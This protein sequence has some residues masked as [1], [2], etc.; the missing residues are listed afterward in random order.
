MSAMPL[1]FDSSTS[2]VGPV[3]INSATRSCEMS[4]VAAVTPMPLPTVFRKSRRDFVMSSPYGLDGRGDGRHIEFFNTNWWNERRI[5][6]VKAFAHVH[7]HRFTD[8]REI[9]V[10]DDGGHV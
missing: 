3:A 10:A 1:N 4:A 2:P 5:S 8:E 6:R 7:R 9:V